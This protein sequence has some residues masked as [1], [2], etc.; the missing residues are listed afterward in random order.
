MRYTIKGT[1]FGHDEEWTETADNK[2]ELF[3]IIEHKLNS[4]DAVNDYIIYD[5]DGEIVD[6]DKLE[7]LKL[8]KYSVEIRSKAEDWEI[9]S[10]EWQE[11]NYPEEY[12][13]A[14]DGEEAI[15]IVKEFVDNDVIYN[16]GFEEIKPSELY[17]WR[18]IPYNE[19]GDLDYS[20]AIYME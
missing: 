11:V 16:S 7:E 5:E 2:D 1:W 4:N 8:N 13:E 10:E 18:A 20:N 14:E 19:D 9:P 12:I 15:E 3:W 17:D 6:D